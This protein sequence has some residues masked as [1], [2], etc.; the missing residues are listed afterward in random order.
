V[1]KSNNKQS[2]KHED[3]HLFIERKKRRVVV[4]H[5]V[6]DLRLMKRTM[7][8]PHSVVIIYLLKIL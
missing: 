5:R 7:D 4:W 6:A 2:I 8:L 3:M 1:L